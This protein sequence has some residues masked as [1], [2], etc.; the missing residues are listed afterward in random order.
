MVDYEY[1]TCSFEWVEGCQTSWKP[2]LRL[3]MEVCFEQ[4]AFKILY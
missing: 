4:L 3:P 2:F 1:C